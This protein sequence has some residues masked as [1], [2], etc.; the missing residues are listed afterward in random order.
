MKDQGADVPIDQGGNVLIDD[1][2]PYIDL[3]VEPQLQD[4]D[5]ASSDYS[6]SYSELLITYW[7]GRYIPTYLHQYYYFQLW[8]TAIFSHYYEGLPYTAEA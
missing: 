8:R 5:S 4:K 1:S 6:T 3:L 7:S 2:S